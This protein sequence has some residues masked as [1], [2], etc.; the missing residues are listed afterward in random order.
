MSVHIEFD[1]GKIALESDSNCWKLSLPKT[2]K[3]KKTGDTERYWEGFK[4]YSSLEYAINGLLHYKI[5]T[6]DAQSVAE[7]VSIIRKEA[8][9]IREVLEP[10]GT[11]TIKG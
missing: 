3:N 2:R 11:L 4:F 7:L 8:S 1:K 10:L 9:K 5:R 6:S